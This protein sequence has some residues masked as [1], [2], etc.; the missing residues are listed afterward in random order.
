MTRPSCK[1][2]TDE[3]FLSAVDEAIRVRGEVEETRWTIGSTR[4]DL[5]AVLAGH[6]EDVGAAPVDYPGMPEKLVLAKA[7]KLINQRKL[8]GCWCGCRGDFERLT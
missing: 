7:R 4:W 6:P 5:A 1:D 3:V 2:I 8:S